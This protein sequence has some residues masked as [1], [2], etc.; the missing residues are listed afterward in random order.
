MRLRVVFEDPLLLRRSQRR[1]GLQRCWIQRPPG[2]GTIADLAAHIHQTFGLH[3][4]C[5]QGIILS[6]DGFVLPSFESTCI[7]LDE[8]IIMVRRNGV[9]FMDTSNECDNQNQGHLQSNQNSAWNGNTLAISYPQ[10][11]LH[12]DVGDIL[13][14]AHT[15]QHKRKRSKK[16]CGTDAA[17]GIMNTS[18]DSQEDVRDDFHGHMV[19]KKAS[20]VL[21]NAKR[22]KKLVNGLQASNTSADY[23]S[24]KDFKQNEAVVGFP[25]GNMV[26]TEIQVHEGTGAKVKKKHSNKLR[27]SCHTLIK[28][29]QRDSHGEEGNV[30]IHVDMENNRIPSSKMLNSMDNSKRTKMLRSSKTLTVVES[31]GD[32][33]G[34]EG[35]TGLR[36]GNEAVTSTSK[37][38]NSKHKRNR[39]SQGSDDVLT[40]DFGEDSHVDEHDRGLCSKITKIQESSRGMMSMK[41][42]LEHSGKLQHSKDK[43][44]HSAKHQ[45]SKNES[46]G[47]ENEHEANIDVKKLPSRSARRKKAKRIWKRTHGLNRKLAEVQMSDS[48]ILTNPSE[49]ANAVHNTDD[50]KEII[51]VVVRPGHIRFES[52]DKCIVHEDVSVPL[53]WNGTMSKRKGQKWGR[54]KLNK[55]CVDDSSNH[56]CNE[57]TIAMEAELVEVSIDKT[58]VIEGEDIKESFPKQEDEKDIEVTNLVDLE[59]FLPLFRL[60]EEGDVLAYRVVELS[61]SSWSPELSTFRVGK[62]SSY[63][64]SSAQ[65][66]LLPL[67]EYPLQETTEEGEAN[68]SLYKEDG[69]LEIDFSS[70]VDVRLLQ[71]HRSEET[72]PLITNNQEAASP[73]SNRIELAGNEVC[74]GWEEL[75]QA[76]KEKRSQLELKKNKAAATGTWSYSAM[77]RNA[78]GPVLAM[79]RSDPNNCHAVR[80]PR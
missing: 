58:T 44:K 62:V 47:N 25:I 6:I 21:R 57:E 80:S 63:N 52:P 67:P 3:R 42:K 13:S 51:P 12:G 20:K 71:G 49:H 50:D 46:K 26:H 34:N 61:S 55:Y 28:D 30:D 23:V 72:T 18:G 37:L 54:E 16:I 8:D 45:A 79:L 75:S 9:N 74:N 1:R 36:N 32:L 66:I 22:R 5:P 29:T 33:Q 15:A 41:H 2:F 68:W 59:S 40:K 56:P 76:L 48:D 27:G 38:E 53:Q 31:H 35:D 73:G 14:N 78:L 10:G 19:D 11:D 43:S 7:L 70:L 65:I 24:E 4:S 77:R 64:C 39:S 17:F 60:P 69:S